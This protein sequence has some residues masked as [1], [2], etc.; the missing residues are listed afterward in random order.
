MTIFGP[1]CRSCGRPSMRR[2]R[3]YWCSMCKRFLHSDTGYPVYDPDM[4]TATTV[5]KGRH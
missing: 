5:P 4:V 3:G 1:R 2:I